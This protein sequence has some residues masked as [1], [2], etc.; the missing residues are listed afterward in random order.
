MAETPSQN[1]LSTPFRAIEIQLQRMV[2][3]AFALGTDLRA[4]ETLRRPTSCGATSTACA[5]E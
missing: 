3:G 4:G 1:R 5:S 2:C